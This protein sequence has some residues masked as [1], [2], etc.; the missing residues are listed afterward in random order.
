MI[1]EPLTITG[2][3]LGVIGFLN[4]AR[5]GAVAVREDV[6]AYKDAPK[7]VL[8]I[9]ED[10][11]L[12]ERAINLWKMTWGLQEEMHSQY[13]V[14]LWG[15]GW[16]VIRNKIDSIENISREM[17][18]LLSTFMREHR[19]QK[20][21]QKFSVTNDAQT[22]REESERRKFQRGADQRLMES[23]FSW[24]DK[25]KFIL[26]RSEDLE[27]YIKEL[28]D[29]IDGPL[30]LYVI[31]EREFH[32]RHQVNRATTHDERQDIGIVGMLLDQA[33]KSRQISCALYNTYFP[34]ELGG[35]GLEMSLLGWRDEKNTP[36]AFK[37]GLPEYLSYYL[38]IS[39]TSAHT[40]AANSSQSRA[41]RFVSGRTFPQQLEVIADPIELTPGRCKNR[42]IDACAEL[43]Q[44]RIFHLRCV[45][46][47]TNMPTKTVT[48]KIRKSS[49]K[50]LNSGWK[51]SNLSEVLTKVGYPSDP[52]STDLSLKERLQVAYRIVECALLLLGT[53]WLSNLESSRITR[54]YAEGKELRYRVDI[55]PIQGQDHDSIDAQ[56]RR[57]GKLLHEIALG[58]TAAPF[59]ERD[60]AVVTKNLGET[61]REALRFCFNPT[62]SYL[63]TPD[64]SRVVRDHP[65]AEFYTK[66]FEP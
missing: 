46:A 51:E 38:I 56:I 61:Y 11:N 48:F 52:T 42:L 19:S 18:D 26:S 23:H 59:Q 41:L 33:W 34:A 21:S 30:G 2:F 13:P 54:A 31:S 5:Q 12:L 66:V 22:I 63:H 16:P 36:R 8:K 57:V 17:K 7:K 50:L 35:L 47:E 27:N 65:L 15:D 45:T 20:S 9:S 1:P 4:L 43:D 40:L 64:Q 24:D 39:R 32:F 28:K 14:A 44:K 62:Q 29:L 6:R 58:T 25:V 49:D 55:S 37:A 53:P 60:L 10:S 3:L